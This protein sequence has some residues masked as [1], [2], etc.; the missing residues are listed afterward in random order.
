MALMKT[1]DCIISMRGQFGGVY[2]KRD[3]YGQHCQAMPRS[4]RKASMFGE[5][6][7]QHFSSGNRSAYAAGFSAALEALFG[8]IA[9]AG[10]FVGAI[11]VFMWTTYAAKFF[12][13][14]LNYPAVFVKTNLN[15]A[16]EKKYPYLCPPR[17]PTELP[18]YVAYSKAFTEFYEISTMNFYKSELM[19]AGKNTYDKQEEYF[20]AGKWKLWHEA[21]IWNVSNSAGYPINGVF[22]YRENENPVGEYLPGAGVDVPLFIGE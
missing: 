11:I 12:V 21:G 6:A 15:R 14:K 20:P 22:W 17:S 7:P 2:F 3:R 16:K 10:F 4:I 8:A 1:D 13:N 19:H 18:D 9:A 5:G